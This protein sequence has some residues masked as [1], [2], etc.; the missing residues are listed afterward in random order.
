[1]P[2]A[3]RSALEAVIEE[4]FRALYDGDAEALKNIPS[5]EPVLR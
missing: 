5:R 4:Y 3:E 1:M 2:D